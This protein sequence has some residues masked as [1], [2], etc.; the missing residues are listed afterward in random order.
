MEL[1]A[2]GSITKVQLGQSYNYITDISGRN[3]I[4]GVGEEVYRKLFLLTG[5][6]EESMLIRQNNTY[7][8]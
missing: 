2:H 1:G 5:N 7:S 3:H 4:G 8:M 6:I